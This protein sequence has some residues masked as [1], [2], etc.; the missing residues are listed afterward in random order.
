MEKVTAVF[1]SMML[2]VSLAACGQSGTGL[3]ENTQADEQSGDGNV[4]Q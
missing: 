1:L 2:L 3:Q 4:T